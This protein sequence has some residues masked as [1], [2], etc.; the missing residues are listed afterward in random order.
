MD[1]QEWVTA[2]MNRD[3]HRCIRCSVPATEVHHIMDRKLFIDGGY[4]VDNGVSVCNDCHLLMEQTLVSTD[5]VRQ[6]AG[7]KT[8]ILPAHLPDTIKY[9]KWGNEILPNGTRVAGDMFFDCQKILQPVLHLFSPYVRYPRTYH[10]PYSPGLQNDD[11]RISTMAD[12][13]GY[14]VVVTIKMDGESTTFYK[15][16]VT[17]RSPSG[18]DMPTKDWVKTLHSIIVG[19]IPDNWRVCGEDMYAVHSI[20]YDDLNSYF[21]GF[22]IWD[23]RNYRLSWDDMIVWFDLFNE[24]LSGSDYIIAIPD[25]IYRG[26]YD[27]DQ[28]QQAFDAYQKQSQNA[29]EGYVVSRTDRFHYRQFATHVAKWVRPNHVQTDRH[30]KHQ[31]RI[32]MTT[33]KLSVG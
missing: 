25:V 22:S 8:V 32:K 10:L 28:I 15:D 23:D 16:G 26:I 12:L 1:R 6:M 13:E 31:Q 21:Y 3:G 14:E 33:N 2:V 5:D 11:R 29:V 24:T 4:V 18:T 7:I 30:W 9:D 19:D 20:S 17:A 27:A